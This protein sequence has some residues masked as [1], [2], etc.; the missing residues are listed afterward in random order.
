MI[1]GV[2]VVVRVAVAVWLGNTVES[3]PGIADQ[4]SY[5]LLATRV[6]TG[7]GFTFAEFWWPFTLPDQPTAHWSYLYTLWLTAI[8]SI[9]GAWPILPRLIQALVVGIWLPWLSFRIA[10]RVFAVSGA[11]ADSALTPGLLAAGWAALYGYFVYYT[12]A[13]ITEAYYLVVVLWVFDCSLRLMA[14]RQQKTHAKRLWIELGIALAVT[15]LLRQVFLLF[16]PFLFLW[17]VWVWMPKPWNWVGLRATL[18]YTGRGGVTVAA[19]LAVCFLPITYFNYTHFGRPVLLNTN[20]GYA[21]FWSNHPIYGDQFIDI[22]PAAMGTYQD[23]IP[24][25]LRS[26]NEAELDAALMQRGLQFVVDDP[27]RYL[28]LSLS[29]IPIYF[30]FWPATDSSLLSNIVRVLS[31]GLALPFMVWGLGLWI[32]ECVRGQLNWRTGGLLLLF[33][34][35]YSSVHL[36]SWSLIRYRAPVDAVLLPFAAYAVLTVFKV[37]VTGFRNRATQSALSQ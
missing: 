8:Y 7:H 12:G 37:T 31:F 33:A 22:L 35:I 21:F 14:T 28:R 9:A 20:A 36:L 11:P 10:N 25:E 3:L 19:I 6:L 17:L 1:I 23:L 4:V 13:L 2:A 34:L 30:Q 27:G 16:V 15:G 29:R 32:R 5:H 18:G 26:L 24:P